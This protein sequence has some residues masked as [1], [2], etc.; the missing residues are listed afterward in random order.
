MLMQ[1]V[2]Y[3]GIQ[4]FQNTGPIDEK[5]FTTTTLTFNEE[6]SLKFNMKNNKYMELIFDIGDIYHNNDID[7][8]ILVD[9]AQTTFNGYSHSP[10]WV[11]IQNNVGSFI[12]IGRYNIFDVSLKFTADIVDYFLAI[13]EN[14]RLTY[15]EKIRYI[16]PPK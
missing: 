10:C 2:E 16:K 11:E 15:L 3:L 9:L 12:L 6:Y 8:K 4:D 1:L 5:E 14:S 7:Q 13:A